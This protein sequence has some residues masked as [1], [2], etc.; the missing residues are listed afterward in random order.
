VSFVLCTAVDLPPY[1]PPPPTNQCRFLRTNTDN[2][3]DFQRPQPRQERS[4]AGFPKPCVAGSNPVSPT[5][6]VSSLNS[7][8]PAARR[9]WP[10]TPKRARLLLSSRNLLL[11]NYHVS[12]HTSRFSA[13]R[14]AKVP[15]GTFRV[16][17]TPCARFL[18]VG[19]IAAGLS[20]SVV[21]ARPPSGLMLPILLSHARLD[22]STAGSERGGG[23]VGDEGRQAGASSEQPD[24]SEPSAARQVELRAAYEANVAAGKAPYARVQIRTRGELQWVMQERGWSGDVVDLATGHEPAHLSGAD[25]AR[26]NLRSANLIRANL[27]GANL[28]NA[29]LSGAHL[30]SVD[31][32]GADLAGANLSRAFPAGANLTG[33]VLSDVNL[34]EAHLW[35]ANLSGTN[36]GTADLSSAD[37]FKANLSR[38]HLRG[39]KL[40]GANLDGADLTGAQGV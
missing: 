14:V 6:C 11:S 2:K 34:S 36:L 29:N 23:S 25:F 13:G 38:A 26:A 32:S 19:T 4:P 33:A 30:G 5:S 17:A 3:S 9:Y 10:S 22:A 1:L 24:D 35:R 18:F 39:T 27:S 31:L 28:N 21:S 8:S 16:S 37:L 7:P 20:A 12:P 40:D 15:V